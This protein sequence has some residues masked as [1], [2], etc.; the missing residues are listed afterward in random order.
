MEAINNLL[1]DQFGREHDYLRISLTERCNLRCF[2]CMPEDGILLKDND[3]YMTQ[4][5]I[6][7]IAEKFVSLGVKKIR[8]TGGE[9]LVRKDI[10]EILTGLSSLPVEIAITTN[11][12]LLDKYISLLKSLK[13]F[14]RR[15]WPCV[16]S[17]SWCTCR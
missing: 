9:P 10:A 1:T 4:S 8:L 7:S 12:I 2:Y 6:I 11:G 15:S 13:I 16:R 3:A 5:E 14:S 17:P